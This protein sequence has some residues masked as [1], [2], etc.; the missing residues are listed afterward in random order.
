MLTELENKTL[1]GIIR[2]DLDAFNKLFSDYYQPLFIFAQKFVDEELAK[3]LVQDCFFELWKKRNSLK[4][5]SSISAYL[6]TIVKNKCFKHLQKEQLRFDK[7][8]EIQWQLKQEELNFFMHSEK[9]ILEFD[10]RDRLKKAMEKL[11]PKC[12]EV[13]HE[14]RH[15]GLSNKEVAE[16]LDVSVKAVE[17]HISK[18]LKILR[19]ELK[20]FTTILFT[21]FIQKK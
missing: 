10:I 20:D 15:N 6:F 7:Q 12:A 9:S 16:R 21:F 17:K 2:G 8:N 11:P 1:E 18:A 13:F 19:K 4:I 3:D 14:S 5:T